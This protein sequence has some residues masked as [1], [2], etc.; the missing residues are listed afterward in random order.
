MEAIRKDS[1]ETE[2]VLVASMLGNAEWGMAME[3]FPLYRDSLQELCGQG[4]V[5]AD[6]TSIWEELLK[7]KTFYDLTGNGVNHPNDLGTACTRRRF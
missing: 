4:I 5:L 1:P 3:Q 2:F 7:R 6:M